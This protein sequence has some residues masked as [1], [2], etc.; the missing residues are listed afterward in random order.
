LFLKGDGFLVYRAKRTS[1]YI[2]LSLFA[3]VI[4]LFLQSFIVTQA[5]IPNVYLRKLAS[6]LFSTVRLGLPA[7]I[8]VYMQRACGAEPLKIEKNPQT[9]AKYNAMLAF[10]GF[11]FIFVFGVFYSAAF[12]SA[13]QSFNDDD[14][15]SALLTVLGSALVPAVFEEFLYRKIICTELTL[16][17]GGFATIISALLFALAHFSFY[18]FPYA[19]ICGLALSFVYLKTGSVKYTVAIHFANNLL[20]YVCAFI[21][22]KADP[23]NFTNVLMLVLIAL[24]VMA[25]GAC[26]TLLPNMKR[27]A[28]CENGNIA[29]SLFLTFPMV[30]YL[31]CAVLMNFI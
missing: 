23:L 30:V 1:E 27:F 10:V 19:F 24:G 26:Y 17:G 15:L 11:V 9:S 6:L 28:V 31:F 29:S 14:A 25:L 8:F 2:A 22:T 21:S 4:I 3:G 12:P 20:G 18:T 5:L 7:A 13:A 16:H